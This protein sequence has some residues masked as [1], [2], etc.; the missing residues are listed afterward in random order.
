MSKN[1]LK[2]HLESNKTFKIVKFFFQKKCKPIKRSNNECL[3]QQGASAGEAQSPP[4][5]YR[6]GDK[7]EQIT[8]NPKPA[9]FHLL[10]T[11]HASPIRGG[12]EEESFPVSNPDPPSS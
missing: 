3:S 6:K 7:M 2:S 1:I 5:G 9:D 4:A 11:P 8:P 10:Q 12:G